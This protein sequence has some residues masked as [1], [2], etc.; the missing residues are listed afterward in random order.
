MLLGTFS[1]NTTYD[2][3]NARIMNSEF[4]SGKNVL[5]MGLGRFGGG[6]DFAKFAVKS[7]A[8]VI[9]TDS[10]SAKDLSDS[11]SQLKDLSIE[12]HLSG[13]KKSDFEKADIVVVNPAVDADNE[14]VKIAR[15]A[16]KFV[17]SQINIFFELCP[18]AIIGIT[19]SNGKSTTAA[20]TAHLLNGAKRSAK[21]K[22]E[23]VWLSG[24]IGNEPLL[25]VID[26]IGSDDLVV[27][28]LSS[29]QAEMLAQIEKGPKVAVLTNLTPNHLDRH[30][31]FAEYCL[32]KENLFRYQRL[33]VDDPCVSI[34]NI[35][36]E[37]GGKWFDKFSRDKCRVC[38]QFSTD[39]VNQEKR[40]CFHL[41]GRFN[42]SHLGAALAISPT[43]RPERTIV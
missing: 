29:F 7:G 27:L 17:T 41:P 36:D 18:A 25:T 16:N 23:K 38:I 10:A 13:H 35:E 2:I 20:L 1:R 15:Q 26:K 19:G 42:L 31:T 34:F 39:D 6:V 33:N 5:V 8:K 40:K 32:A 24:N 30:G 37:V 4:F 12:F 9:V 11:V 3:H 21:T 22:Y 43:A 14:F 28:E